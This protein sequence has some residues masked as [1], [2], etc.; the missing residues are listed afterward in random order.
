MSAYSLPMGGNGYLSRI[1]GPDRT[2]S[3][4]HQLACLLA[5]VAGILN[6]VGFVA[7][8]FYTSHMTGVT[9]LVADQLVLGNLYLVGIGLLSFASFISGAMACAVLFNWGR[10]RELRSRYANVLLLEGVLMLLFGLLAESLTV[11]WRELLFVPVLC[12]TMGLQNAIITKISGAQIRTTHVTGMVTDIGIELGKF[13][14]R[15][16]L[17]GADPVRGSLPKVSMLSSLVLLFFVGGIIG[18]LGYLAIGFAVLVPGAL[19]LLLVSH[20]PLLSDLGART[21]RHA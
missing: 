10:R 18:A 15:N 2:P 5:L 21:E 13:S 4:N 7:V 1:A 9:A 20:R 8:V 16:R 6:S 11:S 14:Y 3:L 17:P 19:A 12:F